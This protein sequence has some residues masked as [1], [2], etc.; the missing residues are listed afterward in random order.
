MLLKKGLLLVPRV[1]RLLYFHNKH[2]MGDFPI[3]MI[4]V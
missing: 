4:K 1:M 2:V 3:T